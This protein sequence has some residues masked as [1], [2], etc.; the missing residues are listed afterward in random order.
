[1]NDR[2]TDREHSRFGLSHHILRWHKLFL[3]DQRRVPRIIRNARRQLIFQG[4]ERGP[5]WQDD[6][7]HLSIVFP[8]LDHLLQFIG[9]LGREILAFGGIISQI[10]QLPIG[11]P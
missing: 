4:L 6:V 10:E 2:F 7:V 3:V 9:P 8:E 1:M 11:F 5:A